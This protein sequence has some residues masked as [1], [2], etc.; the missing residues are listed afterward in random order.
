LEVEGI[1]NGN[2]RLLDSTFGIVTGYLTYSSYHIIN[3]PM[4]D[5]VL[6]KT[7][8]EDQKMIIS[9]WQ[10][11]LLQEEFN[12]VLPSCQKAAETLLTHCQV[13]KTLEELPKERSPM[14][15]A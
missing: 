3:R 8:I 15:T 14:T 13:L 5:S 2:S 7:L 6:V 9:K 4:N 1:I 10:K 11:G 12:S